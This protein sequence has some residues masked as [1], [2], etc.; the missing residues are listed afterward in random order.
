M[1][2]AKRIIDTKAGEFAETTVHNPVA[3]E[4][5][6]P[7]NWKPRSPSSEISSHTSTAS[8]NFVSGPLSVSSATTA[9]SGLTANTSPKPEVEDFLAWIEKNK[10]EGV[11]SSS[12][13]HNYF[14]PYSDLL[15][16]FT[17]DDNAKLSRIVHELCPSP[18][19]HPQLIVDAVIRNQYMRVFA[20]LLMIGEGS[21]VERFIQHE[22]LSDLM[23]PFIVRPLGFPESSRKDIFELFQ[24]QQWAFIPARIE[25][26]SKT[27]EAERVLPITQ[28]APLRS[29]T[30]AQI[31]VIKIHP[32]YNDLIDPRVEVSVCLFGSVKYVAKQDILLTFPSR[33]PRQH[34]TLTFSRHISLKTPVPIMMKFVHFVTS[35]IMAYPRVGPW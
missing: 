25:A 33:E 9:A 12:A 15:Q 26:R 30:S 17:T 16:Y 5:S 21:Y 35:M 2:L 4:L 23:M 27:V 29:S 28:L 32:D 22:T 1:K 11:A 18:L 3:S 19:H 10:V 34:S 13:S 7:S 8:T 20:T 14:V 6:H 31:N 24:V